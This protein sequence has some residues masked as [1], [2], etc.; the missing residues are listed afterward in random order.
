MKRAGNGPICEPL[1][2]GSDETTRR[3]HSHESALLL[4]IGDG[5][6]RIESALFL[7]PVGRPTVRPDPP[8][9]SNRRRP[10]SPANSRPVPSKMSDAC[11]GTASERKP[12]EY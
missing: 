2:N 7:V 5:S 3:V 12:N 11:S 9:R 4:S 6:V 10:I 8:Y 1:L